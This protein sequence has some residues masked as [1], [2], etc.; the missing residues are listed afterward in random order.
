MNDIKPK[1]TKFH[2]FGNR[3]ISYTVDHPTFKEAKMYVETRPANGG[4][5]A[6]ESHDEQT[7][8]TGSNRGNAVAE[9]LK[10]A[11]YVVRGLRLQNAWH[12]KEQELVTFS[13]AWHALYSGREN[14]DDTVAEGKVT[15]NSTEYWE[16]AWS[17]Y[18]SL[19]DEL[20]ERDR[21][22]ADK[23]NL[24]DLQACSWCGCRT[25]DPQ[26]YDEERVMHADCLEHVRLQE[27]WDALEESAAKTEAE[28]SANAEL[29]TIDFTPV[30]WL[31]TALAHYKAIT[32]KGASVAERVIMAV[33]APVGAAV[34]VEED[35]RHVVTVTISFLPDVKMGYLWLRAD[36]AA[37]AWARQFGNGA[38]LVR[39]SAGATLSKDAEEH[40]FIYNWS[41]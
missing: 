4:W 39:V 24:E 10:Q 5:I 37:R 30:G 22:L 31:Q 40:R 12:A 21:A 19:M 28:A 13:T 35:E 16:L 20:E 33:N 41:V 11:E 9:L 36:N 29:E 7:A 27:E 6:Y 32:A 38:K 8:V 26:P 14:A 15:D 23:Y 34:M 3:C 18:H 17:G 25:A 2:D 1:Y